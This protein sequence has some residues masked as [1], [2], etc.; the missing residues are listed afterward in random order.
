MGYRLSQQ[1]TLRGLLREREALIPAAIAAGCRDIALP[2]LNDCNG[3][4][5]RT[6]LTAGDKRGEVMVGRD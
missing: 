5:S 1:R 2:A 6:G 4:T 3:R